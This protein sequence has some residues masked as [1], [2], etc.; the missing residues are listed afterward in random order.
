MKV[1]FLGCGYLGYNLSECLKEF[2]DVQ[3]WGLKSPYSEK[4]S[5]FV[6]V[7]VFKPQAFNERERELKDA[8]IIDT[9]SI[10]PSV[11]LS[12]QESEELGRLEKMYD[13]LFCSLKKYGIAQ[14]YFLSSGGTVYGD[15]ELPPKETDILN[16]GSL[17][18]RSKVML[19]K[20]LKNSGLNYVILRVSNPYGGYQLT[21]KKQGVIPILIEKALNKEAFE[22][23]AKNDSSRD[24]I[25]I[26]D[27]ANYINLLINKN[28][29]NEV[30]NIGSG[31]K[32][33][34]E[35]LLSVIE[36]Q[37]SKVNITFKEAPIDAIHSIVLD[38]EKLKGI[39]GYSAKVSLE[40]GIQL[41]INRI[42]EEAK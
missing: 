4:S 33:T 12:S 9:I 14:Y 37:L 34:M 35:Q 3:V 24:Y 40:E 7:D 39:T 36:T 8:I 20:V 17:Y 26:Q 16:P 30:I 29:V 25:Y 22:L 5:I 6:E 38:T 1:I 28:V 42:K 32:V 13:Q 27:M 10:I 41:E 19:E 21:N 2:H 11:A 18:A 23:W 31:K 15:C